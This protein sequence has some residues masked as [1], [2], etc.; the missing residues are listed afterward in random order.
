[1]G[2]ELNRNEWGLTPRQ[3]EAMGY[4]ARGYTRPE[5]CLLMDIKIDALKTNLRHA[6]ATLGLTNSRAAVLWWVR[7]VGDPE[8]IVPVQEVL[9][10]RRRKER[11]EKKEAA[12]AKR[13]SRQ[14]A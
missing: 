5:T 9:V 7:N 8:P 1:M 10:A 14:V 6:Y 13:A 4:I 2:F 3:M 12:L 11:A